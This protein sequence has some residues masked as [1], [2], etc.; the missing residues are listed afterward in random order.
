MNVYTSWKFNEI[1]KILALNYIWW[2]GS[3]CTRRWD[4]VLHKTP[5]TWGWE[6][7]MQERKGKE[8][9]RGIWYFNWKYI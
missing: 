5:S 7:D 8:G 9:E 1:C 6:R 2:P 4:R 3:T